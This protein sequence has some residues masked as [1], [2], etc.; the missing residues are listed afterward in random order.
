M[1]FQEHVAE[2]LEPR[3]QDEWEKEMWKGEREERAEARKMRKAKEQWTKRHTVENGSEEPADAEVRSDS[4]KERR[5]GGDTDSDEEV[6]IE[7]EDE[8]ERSTRRSVLK[9]SSSVPVLQ[10]S[11]DSDE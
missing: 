7:D 2:V 10:S 5:S 3:A 11:E 9:Q 1:L 8:V 4:G 6:D